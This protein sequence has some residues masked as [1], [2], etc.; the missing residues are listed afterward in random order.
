LPI[1]FRRQTGDADAAVAFVANV[2]VDE[3]G[4]DLLEDVGVFQ[5]SAIDGAD[6]RSPY[7][8]SLST[9]FINA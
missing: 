4:G 1:R 9:Q 3:Q 5:F 6:R 8:K 2:Q 7:R